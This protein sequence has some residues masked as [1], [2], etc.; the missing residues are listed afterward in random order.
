MTTSASDQL[1]ASVRRQMDALKDTME[2]RF[3]VGLVYVDRNQTRLYVTK[4]ETALNRVH[5]I[6]LKDNKIGTI[7]AGMGLFGGAEPTK[8]E[9]KQVEALMGE[10]QQQQ[11]A[12]CH[13]WF[14]GEVAL[15]SDRS[16]VT[17]HKAGMDPEGVYVVVKVNTKTVDVVPLG[18]SNGVDFLRMHPAL[19]IPA[20]LTS[21]PTATPNF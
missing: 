7:K 14:T 3:K 13:E 21:V 15:L 20:T 9:M 5:V 4:V 1:A 6:R 17:A 8:A 18:T 16:K 12:A 19:L 10:V 11:D 2:A